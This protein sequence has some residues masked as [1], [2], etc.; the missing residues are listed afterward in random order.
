MLSNKILPVILC[1]GLGTRL[2]PL[3]RRSFPKQ[4][5][6]LNYKNNY[7]LIQNTLIRIKNL[8]NKNNPI[9]ICNEE[10][11]FIVAEQMREINIFPSQIILEPFGR[12]TAPAIAIAAL[13]SLEEG[14]DQ[15]LLI[16]SSDHH[17]EN[18]EKFIEVINSGIQYSEKGRLVTFGVVPKS[19]ETGYGYI[20]SKDT[21]NTSSNNGYDIEAFIEK[22]NKEKAKSF[23]RDS[24]FT[25]NSGIFLFKASEILK[26]IEKF[27][28]EIITYCK[29][30]LDKK[31]YDFDFQRLSKKTFI[32]CPNISIDIAVME[33]TARGTVIPLDVGWNDIGS[34]DSLWGISEKDYKG[35]VIEGNVTIDNTENC[36][37]RSENRLIAGIGLK[38]LLVVETNDAI[39]VAEKNQSQKVKNIVQ[40]LQNEKKTQGIEHQKI[41]RPWGNYETLVIAMN[42]QVKIIN[43]KQGE[44]LS[45]QKHQYRSEHWVVVS[46]LAKVEIDSEII[47]LKENQSTYIPL[48]SK[49]RLSNAGK[50]DLKIIEIQSGSYIGEDD[51]IRF[52]DN[53]GR[54]N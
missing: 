16:L 27:Y 42:W 1:G 35:N 6:S 9:L 49:H 43:V 17:I 15:N 45:L 4:F 8:D 39:L 3:S 54:I 33:K 38:N 32:K 22:P 47:M 41:F 29:K 26:E 10:H 11:R 50:E 52:E 13:K 24:R 12:N 37:L 44:R 19:P 48:G 7:S 18:E 5:L 28:P 34:W 40:K 23:L 36:Y 46:G 30:S 53:Y 21:K 51:I 25:W 31:L 2:W 20:K 14:D